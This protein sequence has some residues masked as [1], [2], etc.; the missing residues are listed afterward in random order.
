MI[1][2]D[3]E[4]REQYAKN[5][6][7]KLNAKGENDFR[8]AFLL[9]HYSDQ[10]QI[11]STIDK[12][13]RSRVYTY[14][15]AEEFAEI[16][17]RLDIDNQKFIFLELDENYAIMMLNSMFTDDI[18]NFLTEISSNRAEEILE[19]L[20]EEKTKNVQASL[21]YEHETAGSVMTHEFISISSAQTVN[22]ILKKLHNEG[23]TA[24]IIYYLYV[25]D[26]EG[27]LIGIVS[28]R[29]LIIANPDSLIGN[30]MRTN[31]AYVSESTDQEEVGRIIK[32]YDLLAVPVTSEK[33]HLLG[34][35]TVDDALDILE[36]ETTE[37]FGELSATKGATDVNLT[38]F[39]A[40]KK[41]SPWIIALMFFGLIT[42]GVIGRFED[43]L[44]SVVL[45]AAFI[46]MIM[47]SGGNVGTQS[48]AVSVRGLALGTIE[49][50]GFWRMV[51]KEFATG[52]MIGF[53]CFL[54]IT[55]L[56]SLLYGNTML[57][58]IVGI[59][60]LLT[61]SVSAVIGSVVPLIINKLNFDPAIASGPFITTLNDIIGLLIY[62]SIATYLM[63]YL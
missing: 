5:T 3:K 60:I 41:R 59:S 36:K 42:G 28:L 14:L 19:S 23:Q 38:A 22:D 58:V 46:P 27:A 45:L 53:L 61:L 37:D 34:I 48:L 17:S 15:S 25:I 30:I 11:F 13:A 4:R 32:K 12:E 49:K 9:L 26:V 55:I 7:N 2:L 57:G 51:K 29:D 18:V 21:A 40:A 16:F 35:V 33:G 52:A 44:E 31:L 24:A 39:T 47:D 10:A 50:N 20:N 43:T 1:K 54:L 62:F 63:Q 6:L 8:D 56:I